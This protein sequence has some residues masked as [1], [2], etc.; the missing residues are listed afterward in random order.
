MLYFSAFELDSLH[1]NLLDHLLNILVRDRTPLFHQCI[2]LMNFMAFVDQLQELMLLMSHDFPRRLTLCNSKSDENPMY[3]FPKILCASYQVR[4]LT[5][6]SHTLASSWFLHQK[7]FL[8][9]SSPHFDFTNIEF[10]TAYFIATAHS[11]HLRP[12]DYFDSGLT[13]IYCVQDCSRWGSFPAMVTAH[14]I[15]YL[16]HQCRSYSGH[17]PLLTM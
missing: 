2:R 5:K 15:D 3:V 6:V 8:G 13:S 10:W 12:Y 1:R 4:A 11:C 16:W 17:T 7:T 14:T 9:Q